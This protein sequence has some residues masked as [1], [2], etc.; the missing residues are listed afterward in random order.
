MK[1]KTDLHNFLIGVD[2]ISRA[3][4]EPDPGDLFSASKHLADNLVPHNCCLNVHRE[5]ADL[6]TRFHLE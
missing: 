3:G 4:A 5:V 2:N 6:E 1:T